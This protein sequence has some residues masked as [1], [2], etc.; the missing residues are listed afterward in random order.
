MDKKGGQ[1]E[2]DRV[3]E[4][5]G[6]TVTTQ[7]WRGIE[8]DWEVA[9]LC[10]CSLTAWQSSLDQGLARQ[11]LRSLPSRVTRDRLLCNSV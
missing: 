9:G 5:T 11:S 1:K 7:R 2:A 10:F 8:G 4:E 6:V 3:M